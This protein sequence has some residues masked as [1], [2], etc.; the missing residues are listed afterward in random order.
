[1]STNPG[2]TQ[3]E[4][5]ILPDDCSWNGATLRDV[6]EDANGDL[7]RTVCII[8]RPAVVVEKVG[9]R[10]RQTHVIDSPLFVERFSRLRREVRDA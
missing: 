3:S 7:W 2:R 4:F 5:G 6:Y 10:E 8:D 1:M 9:S